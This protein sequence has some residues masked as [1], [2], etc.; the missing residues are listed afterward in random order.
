MQHGAGGV[1]QDGQGCLARRAATIGA[2]ARSTPNVVTEE[3]NRMHKHTGQVLTNPDDDYPFIALIYDEKG[4]VVA[5]FPA[6][7]KA[8]G[9]AK[10]DEILQKVSDGAEL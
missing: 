4:T 2:R 9:E 6:R 5:S 3:L 7:T 8:D 10:I 1:K